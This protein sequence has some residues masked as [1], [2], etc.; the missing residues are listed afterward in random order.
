MLSEKKAVPWPIKL[1]KEFI[2]FFGILLMTGGTLCF[3]SYALSP[4]DPSNV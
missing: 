3:V 4:S 2:G 1:G